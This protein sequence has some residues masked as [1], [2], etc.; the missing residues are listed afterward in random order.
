MLITPEKA[1]KIVLSSVEVLKPRR[2]ALDKALNLI[3]AE[4]IRSDRDQPPK[5]RSAM[6]GYAV[7]ASDVQEVPARLKLIG[8]IAAGSPAVPRVK[9]GTCATILTGANLPPGADAVVQV[10]NTEADDS[11]VIV[12]SPID[13]GQNVR[14]R[15]E[16]AR[17]GAVLLDEGAKLGPVQV[18]VCA[19]VGKA[20]V[21]VHPRPSVAVVCTGGE[22][23]DA[24]DRVS[25]H[26]LRD[27]NG[28][29]LLASLAQHGWGNVRRWIVPDNPATIATR[30]KRLLK[31]HQ[32]IILT[33]GVSVGQYDYVP[34]AVQR[35][36]GKILFHG[37]SMKPGKPQLY[38]TVGR[39]QHI[40]GLPGNPVSVLTGFNELVLPGLRRMIGVCAEGV[41]PSMALPLA[42]L[43]RSGGRRTYFCLGRLVRTA[44]A[45]FAEPVKSKGSA[46]LIA[47][48]Q[49]DGVIVIPPGVEHTPAGTIVEFHPWRPLA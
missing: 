1:L 46:D 3:L 12:R 14:K 45:L 23:K 20:Q 7:I 17:R 35:A 37:I 22:V 2:T 15:G 44:D 27:S 21:K 41:R 9:P 34:E 48:C 13:P 11:E 8:E 25:A 26:Q 30:L 31:T 33:G 42:E 38:A 40:F 36:G 39:N 32:V 19:M 6:D 5:D 4:D 49:A 43:V 29:A 16:E 28:P 24:A 10:E 47:A 18:G